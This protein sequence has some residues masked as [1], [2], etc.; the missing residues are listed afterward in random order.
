MKTNKTK[1]S[2]VYSISVKIKGVVCRWSKVKILECARTQ[3]FCKI[4]ARCFRVT[5]DIYNLIDTTT[6]LNNIRDLEIR[7]NLRDISL[8]IEGCLNLG[9]KIGVNINVKIGSKNLTLTAPTEGNINRCGSAQVK[10]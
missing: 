7:Q 3:S 1:W 4:Y 2:F 9:T 5:L 6:N 10:I 8:K